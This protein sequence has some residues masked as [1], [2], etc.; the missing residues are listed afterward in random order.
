VGSQGRK[1]KVK[2]IVVVHNSHVDDV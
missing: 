1:G 2:S